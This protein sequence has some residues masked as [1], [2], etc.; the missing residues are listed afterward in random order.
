M[1]D[2]RF[3]S[4]SGLISRRNPVNAT[5]MQVLLSAGQGLGPHSKLQNSSECCI[6]SIYTSV[7]VG[8]DCVS[9]VS[10]L[11]K[12][13]TPGWL[14]MGSSEMNRSLSLLLE[15]VMHPRDIPE[16]LCRGVFVGRCVG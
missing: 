11:L 4:S 14:L 2:G 12:I 9:C 6:V 7:L 13:S 10:W 3:C 1:K 8:S 15:R 16:D 5:R